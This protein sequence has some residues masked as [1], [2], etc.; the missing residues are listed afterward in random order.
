MTHFHEAEW[1][2]FVRGLPVDGETDMTAH[3]SSCGTCLDLV[4]ALRRVADVHL[5]DFVQ[6]PPAHAIHAARAIFPMS[7]PDHVGVLAAAARL[8]FDS[9][10]SP[11]LAGIRSGQPLYRQLLYETPPYAIDLRIEQHRGD[12]LV[13]LTGQVSTIDPTRSISGVRVTLSGQRGGHVITQM[14]TNDTGEFHCDYEPAPRLQLKVAVE[15]CPQIELPSVLRSAG[16]V[17]KIGRE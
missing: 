6:A 15:S 14:Q 4:T 11:A 9:F 2:D 10:A 3:L 12:R 5:R 8:V 17:R 16:A 7:T 13:S 1:A